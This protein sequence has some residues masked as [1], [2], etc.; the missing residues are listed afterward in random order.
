MADFMANLWESVFTPG[1]TPTLI[2]ATNVT[3]GALQILLAA[4]LVATY[5]IHFAI[6]SF[7]C[8]GLWYS[9]NWFAR[10]IQAGQAAEQ[11]AER[12]RRKKRSQNDRRK[13]GEEGDSADDEGE[14]TEVEGA[15][16]ESTASLSYA[17][18]TDDEKLGN[19]MLDTARTKG[20]EAGHGSSSGLHSAAGVSDARR[21][22]TEEADRS[23][24]ISTDS[25]WEKIDEER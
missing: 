14:D 12:L 2:I 8:G 24:E 20:Q 17:S 25:D 11:E 10:E 4:L 18:A 7:L 15:M 16:K 1:A 5:S 3:F 19:K 9:I 21:R 22:M 6:L 23:G 13:E